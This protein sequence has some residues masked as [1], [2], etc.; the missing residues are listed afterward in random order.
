MCADQVTDGGCVHCQKVQQESVSAHQ[1]S[2]I[3]TL[4]QNQVLWPIQQ[5]SMAL[6]SL[7][8]QNSYN[9][10]MTEASRGAD[11]SFGCWYRFGLLYMCVHVD[12]PSC[13]HQ[14]PGTAVS[15]HIRVIGKPVV[16]ELQL[17]AK[18]LS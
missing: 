10:F 9:V 2:L 14:A 18:W 5:L 15:P 8:C 6:S 12:L 11:V 3:H 1:S 7:L 4:C 17:P 16:C 13:K